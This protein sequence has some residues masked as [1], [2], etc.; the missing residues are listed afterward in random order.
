M[1]LEHTCSCR[2]IRRCYRSLLIMIHA[3]IAYRR[4]RALRRFTASHVLSQN[5]PRRTPLPSGA[6]A[7]MRSPKGSM[8]AFT[9]PC[10]SDTILGF[11]DV[12]VNY[13]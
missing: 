4:S 6:P 5:Y 3:R 8:L 9:K 1:L 12:K 7:S 10:R 13:A 2:A 11:Y